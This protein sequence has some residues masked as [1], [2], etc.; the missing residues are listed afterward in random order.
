M[1]TLRK[2]LDEYLRVRRALG[3]KLERDARLLPDFLAHLERHRTTTVTTALALAWA[4]ESPHPT[5]DW[6]ARRLTVSSSEEPI[7]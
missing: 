7:P 6:S 4:K 5:P 2:T 3:F 1:N